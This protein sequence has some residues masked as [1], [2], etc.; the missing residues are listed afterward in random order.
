MNDTSPPDQN[1]AQQKILLAR[2]AYGQMQTCT[3]LAMIFA[4]AG[5]FVFIR[6][7]DRYI[8]PDLWA[9]LR[10]ISTM[11]MLLMV[12]IPALVLSHFARRHEKRYLDLIK[13]DAGTN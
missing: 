11:G 2:A 12:F 13:T 8:A 7:Y 10:D 3:V 1:N 9:A 5:V 6:L 4:A